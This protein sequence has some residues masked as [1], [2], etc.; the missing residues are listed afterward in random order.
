MFFDWTRILGWMANGI[1]SSLII[2]FLII[3]IFYDQA[4]ASNGQTADKCIIGTTMF[5]SIIWTVNIQIFLMMS[6]FTWIQHVFVWGSII[7]WYQFLLAFGNLS[8]IIS[9][10]AYKI[11]E[12]ALGP[13]PIF[14]FVTFFIAIVCN[15]PYFIRISFERMA[16]PMDH[17]VI[18]EIKHFKNDLKDQQMWTRERSK[19]RKK[20]KIGF[21]ARVEEKI[22]HL[23]KK[24]NK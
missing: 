10:H 9:G 6:H 14:W 16:N 8:P 23:T 15:I 4:F 21:T 24:L 13:T 12:E 5:T 18:Q 7:T 19:A 2:F 22:R 11:L 17:H 1:L 20:S 3:S